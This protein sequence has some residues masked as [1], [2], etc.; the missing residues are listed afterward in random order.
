MTQQSDQDPQWVVPVS[1]EDFH[2]YPYNGEF[3][4]DPQQLLMRNE[5]EAHT[6]LAFEGHTSLAFAEELAAAD[7]ASFHAVAGSSQQQNW[8]LHQHAAPDAPFPQAGFSSSTEE[9]PYYPQAHE[10][11]PAHV[12]YA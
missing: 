11:A 8:L 4:I 9:L 10:A 3:G 6:G 5:N 7:G 1:T 2:G 12:E